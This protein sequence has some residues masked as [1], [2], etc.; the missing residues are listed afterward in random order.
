MS[1]KELWAADS[2]LGPGNKKMDASKVR[3][4]EYSGRDAEVFGG[5]N[6]VQ[7]DL[8]G[9]S[10]HYLRSILPCPAMALPLLIQLQCRDIYLVCSF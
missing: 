10:S 3:V 5:M 9:R 7:Y 1:R 4:R 6:Y 8:V 2:G